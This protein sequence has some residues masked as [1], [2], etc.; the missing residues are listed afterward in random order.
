MEI[1]FHFG[2]TYIVGRLAGFDHEQAQIIATCSQYVDDTVN[3]G[4][5]HFKTGEAYHRISSAHEFS[6]YHLFMPVEARRVW[7]PFHFLPGCEGGGDPSADFYRRIVCRPHSEVAKAMARMCIEKS[8]RDHA[9]HRL[10]ITAHVFIDTWAH[11]GFAGINHPINMTS[12]IKLITPMESSSSFWEAVSHGGFRA[13]LW[14]VLRPILSRLTDRFFPMGHGTVL[15]YPDHPF[16][17]WSYRNGEGETIVRNNPT[18]FL[19]AADQLCRLFRRFQLENPD[20]DVDGLPPADKVL[21]E[22]R[23]LELTDDDPH[24]RLASWIE[25]VN[26]GVFSFGP[27]QPVYLK[28]GVG[29]WKYEALGTTAAKFGASERFEY[30]QGFLVSNWKLFHDAATAHQHDVLKEILPNFGICAI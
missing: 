3:S 12:D 22:R 26:G 1:D 23:V 21:I 11:Q 24:A 5:I 25:A 9:L 30:S 7:I 17:K 2:V 14:R 18:A 28:S 6:D 10:G 27:A 19:E 15:H 13:W 20:A 8:Q 16:R 4:A 29:S